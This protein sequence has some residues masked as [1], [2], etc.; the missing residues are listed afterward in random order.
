MNAQELAD[1]MPNAAYLESDEPEM[2][3]S[4]HYAQ[5]A[6]LVAC[7]EMLWQDKTDFFLSALI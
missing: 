3:S 4:L 2:E 7:L 5:L 6:L 1:L